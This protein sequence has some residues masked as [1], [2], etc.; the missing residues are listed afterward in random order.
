MRAPHRPCTVTPGAAVTGASE[1]GYSGLVKLMV[2]FLPDGTIN[3]IEVLEQKETPGLG[4]KMKGEKFLR[5]FRGKDPSSFN[6][7]VEKDGGGVD[8]LA[9][10]TISTRAFSEA[11]QQAYDIFITHRDSINEQ[12][13]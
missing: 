1:K 6:L 13:N 11:T 9:G 4:T 3:N 5:Q 12:D 7:K 10:A 2:G 8:A